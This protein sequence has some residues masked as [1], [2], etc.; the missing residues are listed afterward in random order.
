LVTPEVVLRGHRLVIEDGTIAEI[1]ADGRDLDADAESLDARDCWVA[2]GLIDVHVHGAQGHDTMDATPEA[3]SGMARFLARHGVTSYLP[4][5]VSAPP[6]AIAAAV[7][8]VG[9]C[10][11]PEDGARHLGVHLEGPYIATDHRGAHLAENVRAPHAD[12]YRPL[13]ESGLLRIVTLAPELDGAPELIDVC[14]E[15]G[16][17]IA[18]G[19]SGATY[20]QVID[21]VERGARQATHIFNRMGGLHH[22]SPGTAGAVLADDRI[23]AQVIADGIHVHPAVVKI[24][25][26]S[27]APRRTIL[28]T[29]AMRAT[30]LPDGD[31]ELGG[32]SVAVTNGVART[33]AGELAGGTATLDVV[34]RN[35][36][37]QTG[38]SLEDALQMATSVPADALGLEGKKGV[39]A[40]GADADVILLDRNL[41]VRATIVAGRIVYASEHDHGTRR[42]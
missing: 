32:Q 26:R 3:L 40:A 11:Q 2:P 36:I 24:T 30:G 1:S 29:D 10:P 39:L 13:L 38:V 31:Y 41:R 20:E 27:K 23:Y 28:I 17:E 22:R 12:E 6:E 25:V 5:T 15:N 16:V 18:I 37:D 34:L 21:A 4:T 19:H 14:V 33:G 42:G 35:A 9:H 7:E 8:N